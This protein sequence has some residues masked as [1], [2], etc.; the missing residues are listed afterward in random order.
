MTMP[1]ML[2]KHR[3]VPLASAQAKLQQSSL[4]PMHDNRDRV[5]SHGVKHC[6]SASIQTS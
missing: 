3:G 1:R 4:D 6:L 5:V 2:H